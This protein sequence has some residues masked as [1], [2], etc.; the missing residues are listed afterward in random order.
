MST[1]YERI[2][3]QLRDRP[4]LIVDGITGR[5][6]LANQASALRKMNEGDFPAAVILNASAA[7]KRFARF[8]GVGEADHQF[9]LRDVATIAGIGYVRM[10]QH[11]ADGILTPSI[12]PFGGR[13]TGDS[14]EGLFSWGDAFV[15]GAIGCLRRQGVRGTVLRKIQPLFCGEKSKK[16]TTRK[17]MAS[18]RS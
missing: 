11:V 16:R 12:R 1:D 13:G 7:L 17:L 18:A 3:N 15:A 10:W 5:V 14:C 8:R 9:S 6:R 2:K 4:F